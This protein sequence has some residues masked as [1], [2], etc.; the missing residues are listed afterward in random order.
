MALRL[1]DQLGGTA[2]EH[3][4]KIQRHRGLLAAAEGTRRL[5]PPKFWAEPPEPVE[6]DVANDCGTVFGPT[7][8][9]VEAGDLEVLSSLKYD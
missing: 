9:K 7:G 3:C 1:N 4:R 5:V 2:V 6:F 8:S